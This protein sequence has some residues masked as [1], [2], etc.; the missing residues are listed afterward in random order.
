M[1][2]RHRVELLWVRGHIGII[3]KE[4]AERAANQGHNNL[5]S[6]LSSLSYDEVL[7]QI[8]VKFFNYWVRLWKEGVITYIYTERK[9]P[10]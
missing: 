7:T 10:E 5:F 9:I 8:K 6:T 3:G 1:N 2:L 4:T